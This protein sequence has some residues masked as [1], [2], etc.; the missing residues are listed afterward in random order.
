M[1]IIIFL[2]E[3]GDLGWSFD[4]P[5]LKGGSSRYLTIGALCVPTEKKHLPKRV[6]KKL[7]EKFGWRADR[8]KKW[9]D[10]KTHERTEF[11]RLARAMCDKHTDIFL[12]GIVV[13][14]EHVQ[15]HIRADSNKLYNYMIRLALLRRMA[16]HDSVTMIHD[17][18]S[19]KIKSGNSLHDY[20]QTELWFTSNAST[21]LES[22]AA[23]SHT[24][25]GIQFAD[26]LSGVVQSR[27]E[28]ESTADFQLLSAKIQ[29][30]TLFF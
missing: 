25:R 24:N 29:L 4:L 26:M 19:I 9:S 28:F 5:Y 14:K 10:M 21:R 1:S 13:R 2:D 23:E 30:N 17:A 7:Y 12:H 6:I 22:Q 27:F 15:D 3:S 20:L 16:A 11:A 18:R 8:E